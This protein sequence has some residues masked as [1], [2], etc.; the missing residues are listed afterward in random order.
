MGVFT[1]PLLRFIDSLADHNVPSDF[2]DCYR[3]IN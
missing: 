1:I 2:G 3:V